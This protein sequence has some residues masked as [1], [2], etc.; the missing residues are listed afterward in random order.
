MFG[1]VCEG[2]VQGLKDHRKIRTETEAKFSLSR[3]KGQTLSSISPVGA[4]A[5]VYKYLRYRRNILLMFWFFG[6]A[7][8]PRKRLV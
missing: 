4:W 2:G 5:G 8:C 6:L 1:P 7:D 3:E